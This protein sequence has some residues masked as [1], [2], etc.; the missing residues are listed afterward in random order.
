MKNGLLI[1][2]LLIVASA[3][4]VGCGD[5][6]KATEKDKA[7]ID[8]LAKE[9]IGSPPPVGGQTKQAAPPANGAV[10]PP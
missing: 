5:T 4:L 8:R 1:S 9:G 3:L 2:T 6:P 10:A 7:N